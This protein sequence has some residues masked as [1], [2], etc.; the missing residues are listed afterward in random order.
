MSIVVSS[1]NY[2][3]RLADV[4]W[5]GGA[6]TICAWVMRDTDSGLKE[7][8][9]SLELA[10]TNYTLRI[11]TAD[12]WLP[13]GS[14]YGEG[15]V[16]GPNP[17]ATAAWYY[18][19]FRKL[20]SANMTFMELTDGGTTFA[21][22]STLTTGGGLSNLAVDEIFIGRDNN[23]PLDFAG[24][25]HFVKVWSGVSLS[26][27]DLLT[28]R[29]YRNVQTNSANTFG[30]W[31]TTTT[32]AAFLTDRTGNA[33]DL[34]ATG[35]PTFNSATPTAVLGDDPGGA[36]ST[37]KIRRRRDFM[38]YATLAAPALEVFGRIFQRSQS[39]LMLPVGV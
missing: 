7:G 19:A 2:L 3:S 34:T 9:L 21:S 28:E 22:T 6:G 39:G 23:Q 10:A 25:F 36:S 12:R 11:S 5:A 18:V 32:A 13:F 16:F 29:E 17:V 1:G 26:D 27:A 37:A 4:L 33:N 14:G 24:K 15:T 8:V 38:S 30:A 31:W 20:A 35:T